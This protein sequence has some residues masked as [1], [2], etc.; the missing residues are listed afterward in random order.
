MYFYI[1]LVKP[2]KSRDSTEWL[3]T[4]LKIW[5]VMIVRPT[6]LVISNLLNAHT[7]FTIPSRRG[8]TK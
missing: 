6:K 8:H 1:P 2:I 3:R 5:E 4:T 7:R